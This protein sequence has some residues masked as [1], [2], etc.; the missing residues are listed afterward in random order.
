M[1]YKNKQQL[2]TLTLSKYKMSFDND[3]NVFED[4][5]KEQLL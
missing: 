3:W 2:K 5:K 4:L 1:N